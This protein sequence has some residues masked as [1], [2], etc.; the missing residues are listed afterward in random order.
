MNEPTTKILIID[1]SKEA[2]YSI[3]LTLRDV[4]PEAYILKAEDG[5][6]GLQLAA[7]HAPD[8]I[9][10]DIIMP[11]IDGFEVCQR[12]KADKMLSTIPVVFITARSTDRE[13]RIKALEAGAEGFLAF[14]FD[15][16]EFKALIKS[17]LKIRK[18]NLLKV[19]EKRF[20][21]QM[22]KHNAEQLEKEQDIRKQ[23]EEHLLES[24]DKYRALFD[25]SL[26]GVFLHNS[27]GQILDVNREAIRQSGYTRSE[28]LQ[29]SVF[30]L[31]S[32]SGGINLPQKDIIKIWKQIKEGESTVAEAI[33]R[34]KNGSV[35]PVYVKSGVLRYKN[36]RYILAM[37]Q[38]ITEQKQSLH[39][40]KESEE[41]ARKQRAAIASLVLNKSIMESE[42]LTSF[43][44]VTRIIAETIG[45]ERASIWLLNEDSSELKCLSLF[46]SA[47]NIHSSGAVLYV[48]EFRKYFDAIIA[49]SRINAHD[50]Q[51]DSRT[52]ELLNNYLKPLGI[53]SLL[54]SGIY[55][56]SKLAGVVSLEHIGKPRTWHPDEEAFISTAASMI[57][58]MIANN[59]RRAA[60]QKL[61]I[62]ENHYRELFELAA[63]GILIGS[64]DG[65]IS[66]ANK[67]FFELSGLSEQKVIGKHL[68]SL[69]FDAENLAMNPFRFDLVNDNQVVER[70][71]ILIKPDGQKVHIEMRSKKLSTEGFQSIIRNITKRKNA[72][73]ALSQSEELNRKLLTTIPDVVIRTDIS[74]K[75]VFANDTLEKNY[76]FLKKEDVLGK[77]MLD[78]IDAQDRERALENTRLMFERPLGPKEYKFRLSEEH[79][80]DIEVNGDVIYNNLGQPVGMVYVIR[81]VT[82][83]KRAEEKSRENEARYEQLY[84][85]M[86][87][88]SDTMP[89]MLWAK[90]LD[91]KYLFANKA[92]CEQLLMA[93]DTT[94]PIGKTD[95]FFAQRER[96]KQPD[97]PN[98]H[99]FG[100]LCMDSDAVTLANMKEMQ[101]DEFGNVSGKFLYLDVRKAPLFNSTGNLIGVVGTARDITEKKRIA[102]ELEHQSNLRKL[103][104]EIS[105]G[106]INIPLSK[107][108]ES[109]DNSLAS[110]AKFVGADRAY[111]FDYDFEKQICINTYEWCSEGTSPQID[112][113]QAVRNDDIPDWVASHVKGEAIYI[114][115]VSQLPEGGLKYILEMQDI[116]SLLSVPLMH[117]GTCIGFVGFDSV[118]KHHTYSEPELQLLSVFG[119]MLVNIS[120][121]QQNEQNLLTA[122][123]KAEESDK[124]KSAFINN[125]SHETRTPLNG[126]I[127]FGQFLSEPNITPDERNFFFDKLS[128]SSDRLLNT[129]SDYMDM[130]R[131]VSGSI[132][133]NFYAFDLNEAL[134]SVITD[135][136]KLCLDKNIWF[137]AIIPEEPAQQIIISDKELIL[138]TLRKIADNAVKFTVSGKISIAYSVQKD[139]ILFA[140]KD[141]GKGIARD[142]LREIFGMFVQEDMSMTRGYEG[143]GLGLTIAAGFVALFGGKIWAES[144]KGK[145]SS[146]YFTVP[147]SETKT[148]I[149][150]EPARKRLKLSTATPLVLLAEDDPSSYYFLEL[151]VKKA[152]CNYLHAAT[153]REAVAMCEQHSDI[154][155]VLMDVMMPEMNGLEAMQ[156]IR[157]FR[158]ELPVIALTAYAQTGDE[159]MFLSAGFDEYKV[160]PI[161]QKELKRLLS[162]YIF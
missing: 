71:R 45:V 69:P 148:E 130:A 58:R 133:A 9:L 52:V 114:K 100:E 159:K 62:S 136:R 139:D 77:N 157:K 89:D 146:F 154:S 90:D 1:D 126:I 24:E 120:Q 28:L 116:K 56:E 144:E 138:K 119:N 37:V 134:S 13:S 6:T 59:Q 3:E 73:E 151:V 160:K 42:L 110:M 39:S 15:R 161:T 131:L 14:P 113:L 23:T 145:G 152:G 158:P 153:G 115:D 155:L 82:E 51:N 104:M 75:I 70:Q 85:M 124:L 84:T 61:K 60:E 132:H 21:D 40:L 44:T 81:D 67:A 87:L 142:K 74:G 68:N 103:L 80:L 64:M 33:H 35:Y 34:H 121:R 78:F 27:E 127:G 53:T 92:I 25:H 18:A 5:I 141:T 109:V 83:R 19:S 22:L 49:D 98:W 102:S 72:E 20:F 32:K 111:I 2:L 63:D 149:T 117:E 123:A 129:I 11:E 48:N 140:V 99:T 150:P 143:S 91:K 95:L 76:P 7:D 125:I 156:A 88:M 101:F 31:H 17:M 12:L 4:L 147:L 29:M 122:K 10:L 135:Y 43:Q 112:Q 36:N 128:K 66:N 47:A 41:R 108:Q 118:K 96:A 8:V 57:T 65:I 26:V 137:E 93:S 30:D 106:F 105:T 54:D 16:Y 55:H 107:V 46:E 162:N 38:D 86:R 79:L 94:E 50:A 97:N